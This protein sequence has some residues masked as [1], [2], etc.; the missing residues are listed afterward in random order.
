MAAE[1]T[2]IP[3]L[4]ERVEKPVLVKQ[5]AINIQ[6][7]DGAVNSVNGMEGDVVLTANDVGAL[8]DDTFIPTTTSQLENDAGFITEADIPIRTSQ[9][10]NDSGF[11]TKKDL[12]TKVSEL[13]NDAGYAT[14]ESV[15][16]LVESEENARQNA[17]ATLQTAIS[18]ETSARQS[19]VSDEATAREAAD[20]TLHQEIVAEA[21]KTLKYVGLTSDQATTCTGLSNWAACEAAGWTTGY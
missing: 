19:A 17:D 21:N 5:E 2:N 16:S 6:K 8:P 13:T 9:L 10:T 3:V 1:E 7:L 12:P 4:Q 20:N 15:E 14:T 11:I 18:D